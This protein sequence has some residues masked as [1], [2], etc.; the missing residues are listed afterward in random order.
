MA[1]AGHGGHETKLRM[2][3]VTSCQPAPLCS[4]T[5]HH[6]VPCWTVLIYNYPPGYLYWPGL[7]SARKVGG[8]VRGK[9]INIRVMTVVVLSFVKVVCGTVC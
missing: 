2:L 3:L 1:R 5:D 7:A 8:E 6:T 4:Q 9:I